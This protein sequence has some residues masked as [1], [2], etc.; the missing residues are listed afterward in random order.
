MY[1]NFPNKCIGIFGLFCLSE[2][3]CRTLLACRLQTVSSDLKL[4]QLLANSTK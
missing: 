3:Q 2:K 4:V 1:K